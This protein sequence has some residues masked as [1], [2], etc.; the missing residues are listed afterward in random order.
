MDSRSKWLKGSDLTIAL[1]L[2]VIGVVLFLLKYSVVD[3]LLFLGVVIT[4]L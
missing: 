2:I 4:V 3:I 1:M